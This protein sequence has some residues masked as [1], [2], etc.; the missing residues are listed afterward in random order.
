MCV[1]VVCVRVVCA[2]V[3]WSDRI[4]YICEWTI[5]FH[6]G[7]SSASSTFQVSSSGSRTKD[8]GY[9]K[10]IDVRAEA[11]VGAMFVIIILFMYVIHMCVE[12][13]IR[14]LPWVGFWPFEV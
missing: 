3:C 8:V 13:K 7:I 5:E 10:C 11:P 12:N 9:I 2:C 6:I 1:R 4:G 14:G